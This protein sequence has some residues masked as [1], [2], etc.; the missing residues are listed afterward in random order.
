M[1]RWF[2]D[3]ADNISRK[4][5]NADWNKILVEIKVLLWFILMILIL[6]IVVW[7]RKLR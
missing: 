1:I 4:I 3:K 5:D 7:E 6:M 2:L